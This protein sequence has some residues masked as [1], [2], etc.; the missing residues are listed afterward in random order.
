MGIIQQQS[1]D[2]PGQP[3]SREQLVQHFMQIQNELWQ[4]H[5]A[6]ERSPTGK[7]SHIAAELFKWISKS[8]KLLNSLREV[9]L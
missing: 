9:I 1:K 4:F 5:K 7:Q 8:N 2:A 3:Q 6:L